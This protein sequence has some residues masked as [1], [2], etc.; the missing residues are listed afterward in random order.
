MC[1]VKPVKVAM[2]VS[3]PLP[4][5][6]CFIMGLRRSRPS[7][8]NASIK[9]FILGQETPSGFLIQPCFLL[10]PL[11][12]GPGVQTEGALHVSAELSLGP[13]RPG[14]GWV[15]SVG[16]PSLPPVWAVGTGGSGSS[17]AEIQTSLF[18][19]LCQ[20]TRKTTAGKGRAEVRGLFSRLLGGKSK[21]WSSGAWEELPDTLGLLELGAGWES[22]RRLRCL[23]WSYLKAFLEGTA[24]GDSVGSLLLVAEEH[25]REAALGRFSTTGF[26][27]RQ[28]FHCSEGQG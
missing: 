20:S 26:A 28:G 17:A 19:R 1:D 13:C 22:Q 2:R 27:F 8:S 6:V 15:A 21:Q 11:S 12:L 24:S 18:L 4:S 14:F 10:M 3:L 5:L 25:G 16:S 23:Y 9:F 7:V